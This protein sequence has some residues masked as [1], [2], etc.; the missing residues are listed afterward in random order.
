MLSG[1]IP[2]TGSTGTVF[3]STARSALRTGGGAA[4][5]GNSFSASAPAS[6]AANASVA[7]ANPG[8]DNKPAAL[9][10]RITVASPCGITISRP[11]TAA[12]WSTASDVMTVPAPTSAR[13]P[14]ALASRS[15]LSNGDGEF[16]GTSMIAKPAATSA[17]P[18]ATAASGLIPR[19]IATNG[20][21]SIQGVNALMTDGAPSGVPP[22]GAARAPRRPAVLRAR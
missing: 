7:V 14:N 9:A 11:P 2:P 6:R 22:A 4:S 20:S 21:L 19:R 18:T 10:A 16:N 3:G 17:S 15:M 13:S 12:T 8:I 5:A 1:A